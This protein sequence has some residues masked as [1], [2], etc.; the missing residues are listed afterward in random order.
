[1]ES[2]WVYSIVVTIV[3]FLI[4]GAYFKGV[5]LTKIEDHGERLGKLESGV[6]WEEECRR[7]HVEADRRLERL[8]RI[9]NGKLTG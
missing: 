1:M 2:G 8:E 7:S 9:A 4:Q 6:V 5:F 3:G